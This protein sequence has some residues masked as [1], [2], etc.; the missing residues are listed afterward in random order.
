MCA[1]IKTFEDDLLEKGYLPENLPPA[2]NSYLIAKA[3]RETGGSDWWSN[4]KK[5][6]RPATYNA[7]KRGITRRTFSL[8]HPSTMRDSAKFAAQRWSDCL[9]FF[10]RANYSL[11]VPQYS[12]TGDR[13][14]QISAH[15]TVETRKIAQ[16]SK[17]RFIA[18]TDISRF[19]HS[20]YTHSLPWAF[21]GKAAAKVNRRSDS[22]ELFFNRA[23]HILRCGQD[24]QTIGIPVGPDTSRLFA[25]VVA[26]AIDLEFVNRHDPS[27]IT[28]IRHVDDVW[29]G[30]NS[31]AEAEQ[32][33]WRY[34][35]AIREFE[36]DINE[37]KTRIYSSDFRFGDAWPT[38]LS[39]GLEAALQS[40]PRQ[41]PERLRAT[42]E[43]AFAMAVETG[44]DGILK[45]V[46]K[47]LD[48]HDTQWS[49]WESVEPFLKRLLVHFGHTVDYVTRVV[50]W[51]HLAKGDLDKNDWST[52]FA[53]LID[54]HGAIGNDSEVC[55]AIYA[56][57]RLGTPI[58]AKAAESVIRNCGALTVVALLNCVEHGL[59][60]ASAFKV[61]KERLR[62]ES[63]RGPLWPVL[64]EWKSR[65]W[66]KHS[67]LRLSDEAIL[68]LTKR[69]ATL[70]DHKSLPPVFADIEERDFS[71]VEE[72]IEHRPSM[73]DE[74]EEEEEDV[75]D[76]IPFG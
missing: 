59:T 22:E 52:L 9:T 36:L 19:Y 23:D 67:S 8:V 34:R 39:I 10:Q 1:L 57:S 14:L 45:Y 7:S 38:E 69:G 25:E 15:S 3:L 31:H 32:A 56:C 48:R 66:P 54:R 5:T 20:I 21:H 33:L 43:K 74:D 26:T 64:L 72:A 30:A 55:W 4:P 71:D 37:N 28:L 40:T 29:I 68:P 65:Q 35:E 76:E 11:S 61:A 58:N 50:V 62:N 42:L 27:N 47:Y 63:A 24:G 16:L 53:A 41:A 46:I 17:Y 49:H 75:D 44:D 2:F 12:E 60:D 70:Y 73:Y 18:K 13:A 51:R 6:V